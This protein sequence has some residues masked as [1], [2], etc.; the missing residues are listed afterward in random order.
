[1]N[2]PK[3]TDRL[4]SFSLVLFAF[5]LLVVAGAP[6]DLAGQEGEGREEAVASRAAPTGDPID[7][8]AAP[9]PTARA[10]RVREAIEVDGILDEEAWEAAEPMTRF[11]QAT[12]R[13]G[14]LATEATEVR[15]VYDGAYLYVGAE[16]H[17]SEP[18][19]IVHQYM[20]QDFETRNED[21]FALSLDTFLDRRNAFLF[22]IN[23]NGAIKDIQAFDD[24]RSLNQA[25]E[26]VV[27]VETRI[28]RRGW[29]VEMAI[30][31][32]TLRFDPEEGEQRWGLQLMR[33]IRR[34]AEDVYWAPVDLRTRVHK[35]SRAGTLTG[36]QGLE[37]GR[38]LS[39]KPYALAARTGGH[40]LP[41]ADR[42]EDMD[43]GFDVKYGLTPRLTLD[44]TFR[45]DF[46][47]VEVDREQVNLTRF[48][49][50]FPERRDFFMENAGI[51]A[52]GDLS[53][54]NY[55]LGAS[56]RDFTL[57][58]SR[59]I[60]LREGRPVP[61]VGGARLTGR[62]GG[63]QV[64]LLS[65]QT[66]ASRV[67]GTG[68]PGLDGHTLPA[69][70]FTVA[71]L[72]RTLFGAAD[73]GGIF[74]NR[75]ATDGSGAFNRSFGTDAN[76][77]VGDNLIVHSY[78]AG[79][80]G[81]EL[82][83][84]RHA[85]RLSAAY[86]DRLW[87]VS[88]LWRSIGEGFDPGVGFVRRTGISHLYGT[89]G[90]HPRPGWPGINTVNPYAEIHYMTDPSGLVETRERTGG[91]GVDFLDGGRFT[92]E[93]KDRYEW[94]D[95]PFRVALADSVPVGRYGFR[96]GVVSYASSAARPFSGRVRLAA[97]GFFGGSRRSVELGTAWS[98]GAHFSG[99]FTVERNEIDLPTGSFTA[100]LVGTRFS[101]AWSTKLLSS[102]FVQYN[103]AAEEVVTN[104]RFNLIH[105]P[106][107]DL[108]LV[109]T[110]RRDA[111]GGTLLDNR[112][113]AKLTKL[114]SF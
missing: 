7:V 96:E 97:G 1:V 82:E 56:S 55:R 78:L 94:V 108:F 84:S 103:A 74:I 50:F 75:Q 81:P 87:D 102:A 105:S 20:E 40:D 79:V 67:P 25:W 112:F 107:S 18:D 85:A 6:P 39:V 61:I 13:T 16:L 90:A 42:G 48:N 35:M 36:L 109:Y 59:R 76:V 2:A 73:V 29:T 9:R 12:P 66:E 23:P 104:L 65:M 113:T 31:F 24:S 101:Y 98:P 51:F 106:L 32:T 47:Q 95:E 60:G 57:F 68:T 64:G 80:D 10:V 3:G 21:V 38:N 4:P 33:R 83:G 30:P 49:L 22:L 110:E 34:K 11:V 89:V 14:E 8:E 53:E 58:H 45:T 69:E 46:S 52:F 43:G 44:A 26:G 19:R 37:P 72:R 100:D 86:R 62:A 77:R 41:A 88:A 54:R 111:T 91:L 99:E 70:N 15:I 114:L 92:A 71:R 5:A 63:F 17:D 93:V 28:H 27:E